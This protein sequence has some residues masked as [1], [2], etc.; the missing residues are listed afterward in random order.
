MILQLND[1]LKGAGIKEIKKIATG[2]ELLLALEISRV[3][4]KLTNDIVSAENCTIDKELLGK[5]YFNHCIKNGLI[6]ND[7][8]ESQVGQDIGQNFFDKDITGVKFV[9]QDENEWVYAHSAS[10]F[11]N[12]VIMLESTYNGRG[13]V[14]L[15]AYVIV[16]NYLH[17]TRVRL[18]INQGPVQEFEYAEL[19]ILQQMGNK[20]LES[21]DV[22]EL[23]YEDKMVPWEAYR[24]MHIQKGMMCREYSANEKYKLC[25][26]LYE[27][28]DIV[29]RYE[30]E[31]GGKTTG[32]ARLASCYPAVINGISTRGLMLTYYTMT[33]TKLSRVR[34]IEK[35]KSN[36]Y[37][38]AD[39]ENF[40]VCHEILEWNR[41]GVAGMTFNEK[42]F[43]TDVTTDD[44]TYQILSDGEKEEEVFLNTAETIY[45]VFRDRGVECNIE[46]F[47]KQ[48]FGNRV[49]KYDEY[50]VRLEM[51]RQ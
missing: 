21:E 4:Q 25:K 3:M 2:S 19:A 7:E 43:I 23:H 1:V 20:L 12:R 10:E 27:P 16:Y 18:V 11:K 36:M 17:N 32:N 49:P 51:N 26:R 5:Q 33:E 40:P 38:I 14:A 47:K 13:Y 41:V 39:K 35:L 46:K 45:A 50:M 31:R 37:N 6:V 48:F 22:L 44:G 28:G 42:V 30:K 34:N 15:M 8:Y 29:L 9:K 24:L